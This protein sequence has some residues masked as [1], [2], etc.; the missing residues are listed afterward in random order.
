MSKG[1]FAIKPVVFHSKE[2]KDKFLNENSEYIHI[3]KKILRDVLKRYEDKNLLCKSCDNKHTF[4][5]IQWTKLE[6]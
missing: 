3:P 5:S 6:K 2:Q 4:G 1:Y